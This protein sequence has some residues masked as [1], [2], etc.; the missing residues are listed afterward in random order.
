MRVITSFWE[1]HRLQ[2]QPQIIYLDS[3]HDT[4]ETVMELKI[5]FDML[6]P[7]VRAGP[8]SPR[9]TPCTPQLLA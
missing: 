3:A 1:Q 8:A 7:H 2:S 5:A 6:P 9:R 4:D